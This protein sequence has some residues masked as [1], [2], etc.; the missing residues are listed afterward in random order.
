MKA[1]PS[2][3]RALLCFTNLLISKQV[4]ARWIERRAFRICADQRKTLC[5]MMFRVTHIFMQSNADAE[6]S[7]SIF[8][9]LFSV[10][11][12]I[13]VLCR[14]QNDDVICVSVSLREH[15]RSFAFPFVCYCVSRLML[16][17]KSTNRFCPSQ[18]ENIFNF[19][20]SVYHQTFN[21]AVQSFFVL[22]N[23]SEYLF[24]CFEFFQ[25]NA[26]FVNKK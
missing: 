25:R 20:S 18:R 14:I 21:C 3:C 7:F 19:I 23:F 11:R 12:S 1:D 2:I 4:L 26:I 22:L 16:L 13:L 6:K 10:K 24:F 17:Q 9:F 5:Q 8:S 15:F